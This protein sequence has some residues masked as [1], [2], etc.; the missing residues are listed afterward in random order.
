LNGDGFFSWVGWGR[1]FQ[2]GWMGTAF[3]SV[4]PFGRE[5]PDQLAYYFIYSLCVLQENKKTKPSRRDLKPRSSDDRVSF[6]LW[7]DLTSRINLNG[8]R[9]ESMTRYVYLYY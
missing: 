8:H 9:K 3:S 2:M 1:L 6:W 7:R 4:S 5:L